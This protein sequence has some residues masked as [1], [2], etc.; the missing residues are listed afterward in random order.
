M[1]MPSAADIQRKLIVTEEDKIKL[2]PM[3]IMNIPCKKTLRH[4]TLVALAITITACSSTSDT[5]NTCLYKA[6]PGYKVGAAVNISQVAGKDSLSLRIL[7]QHFNSVV[8]EDCMKMEEVHPEPDTWYWNQADNFIKF[9]HDNNMQTIGHCLI[10]H[11]QCPEWFGKDKDGNP[12]TPEAL[13]QRMKDHIQTIVSRYKGRVDGWDVVNEAILDDGTWRRNFYYEILGEEY[14]PLAFEYAHEA[15]PDAELYYNDYSM[16]HKGRRDAVVNLIR[17]LKK[18]GCRIDAVGMQCHYGM[19]YPD[20]D[21]FEKS[22]KAFAAEGVKVMFTEVDMGA[23]PTVNE[24]ANISDKAEY[25]EA[26]NPYPN[27]LPDSVAK[28][29][30]SRM[31][32]FFEIVNRN[33][34]SVS[35][36]TAWGVTDSQSWKNNWPIPGRKDYP[37][38]FDREGNMKPFLRQLVGK[39]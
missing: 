3:I 18:R 1:A 15:D 20:W 29:W 16:F 13:K 39:K 2:T 38:W 30:N 5:D 36:V 23:L 32:R 26:L 11:S 35:R 6:L 22:I 27:E 14:I 17:T 33:A 9:A 8:A 34:E 10:W 31:A 12:L 37:L 21:E 7:R 4:M 28:V 24:G 19:D 25:D